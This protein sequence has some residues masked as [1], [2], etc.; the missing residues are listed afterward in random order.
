M[1]H[2]QRAIELIAPWRAPISMALEVPRA[3]LHAPMA[4][5]SATGSVTWNSLAKRGG[6][7]SAYYSGHQHGGDCDALNTTVAVR[8]GNSDS[9]CDAFRQEGGGDDTVHSHQFTQQKDGPQTSETA[10]EA[11]RQDREKIL[12]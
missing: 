9:G 8:D 3:W 5:P 10:G 2:T 12:L 1:P 11:S 6:K 4:T 7:D